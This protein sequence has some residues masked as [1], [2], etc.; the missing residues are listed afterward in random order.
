MTAATRTLTEQDIATL[1]LARGSHSPNSGGMCFMEAASLFAGEKFGDH[2]ACVCPTLARI[3]RFWNDSLPH[4]ERQSL[5]QYIPQV[6]GTNGGKALADQRAW[7]Y[8][9]WTLRTMLPLWMQTEPQLAQ[10]ATALQ[11]LPPI[12]GQPAL[13]QALPALDI[14]LREAHAHAHAHAHA[15][16]LARARGRALDPTKDLPQKIQASKHKL[17]A[18]LIKMQVAA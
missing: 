11:A 3:A 12:T 14:A 18:S 9:D 10:Q 17:F 13:A 8:I 7:A 6:V 2:P 16:A 15:L 4:A 5:K 1:E